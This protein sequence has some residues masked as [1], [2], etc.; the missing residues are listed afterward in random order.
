MIGIFDSGYG[1]LTILQEVHKKLP[2]YNYIYLGDNA[3]APYGCRSSEEIYQFTLEAVEYL[4]NQG[5]ELVILACNTASSGPLRRIQQEYLPKNHPS[6]RVLGIVV[7]TIEQITQKDN[8]T[9]GILA[10][11]QTINSG[12][13][14]K[15]IEKRNPSIKVKQQACPK[16]VHLIEENQ[17]VQ[18]ALSECLNQ[19]DLTD[20]TDLLLGCTHYQIIVDEIKKQLPNN[21][22]LYGQPKI[23]AKSLADYLQRHPE[24]ESKLIKNSQIKF[25]T[26]GDPKVVSEHAQIFFTEPFKFQKLSLH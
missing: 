7:P 18:E 23:V 20:I 25:L 26:S 11:T 4:F 22:K 1:G 15:E 24:I 5:C 8:H 3:R 16:L 13:Y 10:T 19:L 12:S 17:P 6:K 21:I 14:L 9:V 2:Q